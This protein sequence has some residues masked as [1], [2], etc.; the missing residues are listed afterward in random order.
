[1][2][3]IRPRVVF[4]RCLGFDRCRYNGEIINDD[5]CNRLRRHVEPVTVC[6]EMEIGL[7]VPRDPIRIVYQAEEP[8]LVQPATGRDLSE[9]MR[10]FCRD[11]LAGVGVVD[12]FVLKSRSPSCGTRDVKSY[13]EEGNIRPAARRRGFFGAVVMDEFPESPVE[14]EGRLKNFLIRESFLSRLFAL[15]RFRQLREEPTMAGLVEFH[16][17]HKLLLM[18]YDQE[19]LRRLGR[20]VANP[21]HRPLSELLT[22]YQSGLAR[23]LSRPPK[24]TNA[25]N[26]LLH[27]FGYFSRRLNAA[28]KGFLLDSLERYRAGRLPLSAPVSIIQ[29]WIVRF[30]ENYLAGQ[31]F[32]Q[33]YPD[34]LRE[35]GDSG[36]GR[37]R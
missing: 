11:F 3:A 14:D 23:A 34:E 16:T 26:V 15:A 31:V 36:K 29:S 25:V 37:D 4:S 30:G 18:A 5:F 27:A 21:E 10:D 6:P 7:G 22:D 35:L 17:T 32:F 12:G 8:R 20:L 13:N 2:S 33:P 28:E 9:P 1:M 19:T 24:Y